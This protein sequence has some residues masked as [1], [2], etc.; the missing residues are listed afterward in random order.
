MQRTDFLRVRNLKSDF[1]HVSSYLVPGTWPVCM[2]MQIPFLTGFHP[3]HRC[4]GDD[5]DLLGAMAWCGGITTPWKAWFV[6]RQAGEHLS[7][8][9]LIF[10]TCFPSLDDQRLGVNDRFRAM[11]RSV[12]WRKMCS[13]PYTHS[14]Y[15]SFP[16]SPKT[17]WDLGSLSLSFILITWKR[18]SVFLRV[19]HCIVHASLTLCFSGSL[20]L[21]WDSHILPCLQI[22]QSPKWQIMLC[23]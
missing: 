21:L 10:L 18:K 12:T 3:M 9:V 17:K 13:A 11:V 20:T 23:W 15:S 5:L 22:S 19:L 16:D 14:H 7:L 8:L 6:M 1:Q 2:H 4:F